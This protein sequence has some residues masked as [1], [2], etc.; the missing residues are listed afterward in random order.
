MPTI[1]RTCVRPDGCDWT[2]GGWSPCSIT[3][4][5]GRQERSVACGDGKQE[6]WCSGDIPSTWQKCLDTSTCQWTSS[7]WSACSSQC[8]TGSRVRDVSC[9]VEGRCPGERPAEVT[10]CFS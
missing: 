3:C 5:T 9:D 2:I 7:S 4:G 6:D 8:G 10:S 1:S